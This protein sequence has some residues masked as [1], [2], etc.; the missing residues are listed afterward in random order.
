MDST[1]CLVSTLLGKLG[2]MREFIAQQDNDR[3]DWN[4]EERKENMKRYI[5]RNPLQNNW[6]CNYQDKSNRPQ[7][8]NYR[9]EKLSTQQCR[10]LSIC[11]KSGDHSTNK[12]PRLLDVASRRNILR[13][14]GV[15][16]TCTSAGHRVSHCK[17]SSCF[18]CGQK[19]HIPI[20]ES[21]RSFID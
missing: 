17:S 18:I 12:Y 15:C 5:E 11:C 4:L 2:L 14:K 10:T 13:K 6:N 20:C 21:T 1:Q 7:H 19:H 9:K 16:F 3:E 8:Q